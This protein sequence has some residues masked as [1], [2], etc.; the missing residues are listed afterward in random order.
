[1]N[2]LPLMLALSLWCPMGAAGE[3]E[4]TYEVF[5]MPLN[6]AAKLRRERLGGEKSYQR[7][8]KMLKKG[9][10][11]QEAWKSVKMLEGKIAI[12]EEVDEL[13]FPTEYSDRR[14]PIHVNPIGEI[15]GW[16][17][18]L[19]PIPDTA[20]AYDTK[21]TG[22]TLEVRFEDLGQG[23]RLSLAATK[24]ALIRLD[25]MGKKTGKVE[26]PRFGVQKLKT[27]VTVV[28]GKAALLG[29]VSPPRDLQ[30][31]GEKRIWLAFA[32]VSETSD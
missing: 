19:F 22:D 3:V 7:I 8:L 32:T 20:S 4:V 21:N 15:G 29:T 11:R 13:I 27:E 16:T 5:S 17:R 14:P 30:K 24:I 28:P 6:D 1:M 9:E 10:V 2:I 31:V 26:M 18:P 12:L 23:L 25:E